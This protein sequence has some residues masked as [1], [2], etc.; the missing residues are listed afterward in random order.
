MFSTMH[1]I[2]K[3][4][5]ESNST[6]RHWFTKGSMEFFNTELQPNV[7]PI[8]Q[9]GSIFITSEYRSDPEDKSYSL[10]YA[11]RNEEGAFTMTTLDGFGDYES[12]EDAEDAAD[13][14]LRFYRE[15]MNIRD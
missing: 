10:R 3:A 6:A 8:G 9:R 4:S 13:A 1:Q 5:R 12:L 2:V 15:V 7:F 11:S 14:Y